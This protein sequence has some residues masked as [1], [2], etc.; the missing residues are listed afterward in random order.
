MAHVRSVLVAAVVVAGASAWAQSVGD[1]ETGI[2]AVYADSLNG[3]LT[4]SG[5][6]YDRT[7]L[8]AAHKRLPFG[9]MIKVTNQANGKSVIVRVNDR[10]PVQVERILDVSPAAADRLG[11]VHGIRHVTLEVVDVGMGRQARK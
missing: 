6:I 8:T 10:G 7:K 3:R 4:A 1:T 5:Q 11:F 9:T 2:A